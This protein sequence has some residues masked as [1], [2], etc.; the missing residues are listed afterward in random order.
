[1]RWGLGVAVMMYS[2]LG[3]QLAFLQGLCNLVQNI[4]KVEQIGPFPAL[5]G[6]KNLI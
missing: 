3:S 5:T 2:F 4:R 6:I 1:M